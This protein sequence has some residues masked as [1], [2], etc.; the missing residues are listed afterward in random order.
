MLF[1]SKNERVLPNYIITY[2]Y[3]AGDAQVMTKATDN[4]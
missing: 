4:G 1:N 2:Q 3:Q